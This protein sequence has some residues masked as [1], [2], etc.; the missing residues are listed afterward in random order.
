MWLWQE[1]T[2]AQQGATKAAKAADARARDAG[3]AAPA[4]VQDAQARLAGLPCVYCTLWQTFVGTQSLYI[5]CEIHVLLYAVVIDLGCFPQGTTCM[6]FSAA[7]SLTLNSVLNP[8]S[9]T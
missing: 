3:P 9:F 2:S 4:N 6:C 1:L 7:P 8:R 5:K